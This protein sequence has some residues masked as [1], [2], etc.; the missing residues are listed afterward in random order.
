MSFEKFVQLDAHE[1]MPDE[2]RICRFRQRLIT[3]GLH[4]ELLGLLNIQLEARGCIVKRLMLVDATLVE[5]SR[6]RPD[7]FSYIYLGKGC[8]DDPFLPKETV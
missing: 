2:T 7:A 6:K 4:K 8:C 1:T 3:C 5:P